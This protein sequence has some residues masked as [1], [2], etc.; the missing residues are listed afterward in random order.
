MT[1]GTRRTMPSRS[2]PMVNRPRPAAAVFQHLDVTQQP[3]EIEYKRLRIAAERGK[4][5][6]RQ[7]LVEVRVTASSRPDSPST[8]RDCRIAS[9][10]IWSLLGSARNLLPGRLVEIAEIVG[11]DVGIE[12]V[13]LRE[14]DVERDD[15]ARP[16]WS[17]C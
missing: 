1:I 8:T 16:A 7:L 2:G 9:A 4:P 13:R 12:P 11:G 6:D 10:K 3:R 5:G 15:H 14:D 17:D